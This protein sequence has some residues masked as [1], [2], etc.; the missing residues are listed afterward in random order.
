MFLRTPED[1]VLA[2]YGKGVSNTNSPALL[3]IGGVEHPVY[4]FTHKDRML[5]DELSILQITP[6]DR[7]A[8]KFGRADPEQFLQ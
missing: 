8:L 6:D 4:F 5:E 3:M 2:P 7:V 1:L